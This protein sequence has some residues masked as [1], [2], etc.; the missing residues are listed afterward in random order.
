MLTAPASADA[1]LSPCSIPTKS[2]TASGNELSMAR[3]SVLAAPGIPVAL[4]AK[5]R[6]D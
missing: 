6:P 5:G 3:I 2:S 4:G 1:A